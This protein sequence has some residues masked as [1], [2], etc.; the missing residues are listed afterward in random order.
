[1]NDDQVR[2]DALNKLDE[3]SKSFREAM[4]EIKEE[5][6]KFWNDLP[7]E[8]KLKVFCAVS[9]RIYDG[10]LRQ[11]GS[12]RYVLYDVF[13]FDMDSYTLALDANY[14]EIHN[15]LYDSQE[16]KQKLLE[17]CEFCGIDKEKVDQ[18]FES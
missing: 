7:Y 18:F 12:Y 17:F 2:Q 9:R 1:M 16:I 10:E 15:S 13:G 8:D 14:M 3:I 11:K 5:Q 6:E 4:D